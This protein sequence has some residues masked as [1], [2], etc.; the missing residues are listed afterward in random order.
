[1]ENKKEK[2]LKIKDKIKAHIV[3]I[4]G[5]I[6]KCLNLIDSPAELKIALFDLRREVDSLKNTLRELDST[7][8]AV[9]DA[10]YKKVMQ[11]VAK[12]LV[13]LSKEKED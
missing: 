8:N 10:N 2:I 1:M 7:E 6:L 3:N 13:E 9:I 12:T 11:N 4:Q 5:I